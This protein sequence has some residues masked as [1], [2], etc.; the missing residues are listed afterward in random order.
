VAQESLKSP[1]GCLKCQGFE[2]EVALR[3][4]SDLEDED[5]N[6]S[7]NLFH[8]RDLEVV[9]DQVS[10]WKQALGAGRQLGSECDL[11]KWVEGD[12]ASRASLSVK[13][14]TFLWE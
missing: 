1:M 11:G 4:R 7:E 13:N 10:R 5:W 8:T 3:A 9:R 2:G 6:M 12:E 14:S